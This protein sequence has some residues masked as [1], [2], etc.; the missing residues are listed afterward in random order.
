[1]GK[2]HTPESALIDQ[3]P[4]LSCHTPNIF[5][6]HASDRRQT[7]TTTT[8][9]FFRFL[10]INTKSTTDITLKNILLLLFF[11]INL[12]INLSIKTRP[13]TSTLELSTA[14]TLKN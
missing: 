3:I 13:T 5:T 2:T 4:N 11:L 8:K 9:P 14:I 12:F 6:P 10:A 1:M 7:T